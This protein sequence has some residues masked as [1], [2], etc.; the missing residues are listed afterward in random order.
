MRFLTAGLLFV[1]SI[2]LVILGIGERTIWSD[3]NQHV[4]QLAADQSMPYYVIPNSALTHFAGSPT[5]T[6]KGEGKV[7]AASGRESDI[8]AWLANEANALLTFGGPKNATVIEERTGIV[9][10][11]TPVGSDLWRT[12]TSGA[13]RARLINLDTA[14][15]NAVLIARDGIK[16]APGDIRIVWQINADQTLSNYLLTA[17]G[18]CLTLAL[19]ANFYSIIKLRRERRPRRKL[20]KAPQG[21]KYRPKRKTSYAPPRGRRSARNFFVA[22]PAS[23][24]TVALLSG[25]SFN[26]YLFSGQSSETPSASPTVEN[27]QPP[28][29]LLGS[30]IKRILGETAY[31]AKM[32]DTG[33][34]RHIITNRFAGAALEIRTVHYYLQSR[35]KGLANLTP[36]S[37]SAKIVLPAAEKSWPRT[38]MAVT[39]TANSSD[40]PQML[41]FQQE[42]PRSN[43]KVW[44]T[45]E[46]HQKTPAVASAAVGAIQTAPDSG[47]LVKKPI[48]IVDGYGDLINNPLSSLAINDFDVSADDF[49]QGIVKSQATNLASLKNGKISFNHVLGSPNILGLNTMSNGALVAL[50]MKDVTVTKPKK[51]TQAIVV[52]GLEKILLGKAGSTTGI[53]TTYGDMM[54]FFVPNTNGGRIRLLGYSFGLVQVKAL[55]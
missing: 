51:S 35:K 9:S 23:L 22:V 12:E 28:V 33:A 42:N 39:K 38:F 50:Y 18:I 20:P 41:V 37:A 11:L 7:F 14:E 46:L 27:A 43:Y 2:V 48:D 45:I 25:C 32:A 21:P 53:S 16:S 29:T 36:I 26:T 31:A 8:D 49:Y 55:K 13:G 6:V 30:Q 3:P 10:G 44:Y 54:L 1:A 52:G 19:I 34:D 5:I 40:A 4:V 15:E 17:G 47:F 24:L